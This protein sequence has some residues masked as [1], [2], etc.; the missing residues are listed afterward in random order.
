M[1]ENK[2]NDRLTNE[3]IAKIREKFFGR[4][5]EEDHAANS[6][7]AGI[8]PEDEITDN[9]L[10]KVVRKSTLKTKVI[11][12]TACVATGV[13]IFVLVNGKTFNTVKVGYQK[14]TSAVTRQIDNT[15]IPTM[16]RAQAQSAGLISSKS[17]KVS[18]EKSS[19]FDFSGSAEF[20][21]DSDNLRQI[22]TNVKVSSTKETTDNKRNKYGAE[23]YV[24]G[25]GE[26]TK[27][28]AV[29]SF[30]HT[31]KTKDNAQ[32]SVGIGAGLDNSGTVFGGVALGASS[33]IKNNNS[34]KDAKKLSAK[35][36]DTTQ[37]AK[38]ATLTVYGAVELTHNVPNNQTNA[39]VTIGGKISSG[40]V[41]NNP[42]ENYDF[43]KFAKDNKKN[44]S[45]HD[46]NGGG[47]NGGGNNGGNN[48]TNQDQ[49]IPTPIED[50]RSL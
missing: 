30:S 41:K 33:P 46:Q 19:E 6:N 31:E 16:T 12:V 2:E 13:I 18:N 44:I 29:S 5:V 40:N 24:L 1:D 35:T 32:M 42:V 17:S 4:K 43:A 23:L 34:A 47:N 11:R 48:G 20:S 21:I 9:S 39:K 14:V 27:L 8:T 10:N 25:D 3:N 45:S 37:K 26:S 38:D 28:G 22:D 7:T 49:E 50:G 15:K 36:K